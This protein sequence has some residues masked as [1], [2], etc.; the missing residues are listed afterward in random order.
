MIPSRRV[1]VRQQHDIG[2]FEKRAVLEKPFLRTASTAGRGKTEAT[3]EI[4]F[5]LSFGEAD[6]VAG[7]N[8]LKEV[9]E[10]IGNYWC[11]VVENFALSSGWILLELGGAEMNP[12]FS[13]GSAHVFARFEAP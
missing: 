12:V 2:A 8:C 3:N 11:G 10:L 9:G 1:V 6:C 4:D 13:G 7:L 5:I